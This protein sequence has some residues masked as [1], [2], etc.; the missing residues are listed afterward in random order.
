M[1]SRRLK[2]RQIVATGKITRGIGCYFVPSQ[3]GGG[4][5][6]RVVLEGLFP[7]CTCPDFET[8]GQPCK[9]MTAA[10]NWEDMLSG[11][12][13]D[14]EA[15]TT[16]PRPTQPRDWPNYN[17]AQVREKEH[18]LTLLADLCDGI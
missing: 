8:T 3:E 14:G 18:F 15:P 9:H 10:R 7:S 2:A 1:E 13:P 4:R 11:T 12:I 16:V 17:K 5:S 6:Y